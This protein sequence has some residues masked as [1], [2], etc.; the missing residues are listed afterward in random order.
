MPDLIIDKNI[1]CIPNINIGQAYDQRYAHEDIHYERYEKMALFFGRNMPL[2]HHDRYFQVH[3]ILQGS[4]R[5]QLDNHYYRV[6]APMCIYT[7]PATPH[8]FVTDDETSGYV[9][10]V[11]QETVWALLNDT[12]II[13]DAPR[14]FSL[15]HSDTKTRHFLELCQLFQTEFE[16]ETRHQH[17][18]IAA[19][20]KL[21]LINLLRMTANNNPTLN[22]GTTDSKT[23]TRFNILI[24]SHYTEHWPIVKYAA[25][26]GISTTHLNTICQRLSGKSCKHLIHDRV[27]VEARRLMLFTGQSINQISYQLGFKDPAYF[28]RFIKRMT[29]LPPNQFRL[30]PERDL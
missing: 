5:V 25:E 30:K 24:E 23:F 11:K 12:G 16:N 8:A 3:V 26:L 1:Q 19:W 22:T 10:T 14:C 17:H 15:K 21:F 13:Y 29:G 7:P 20:T 28:S 4:V 18:A 2:H 6:N 27:F 9:M